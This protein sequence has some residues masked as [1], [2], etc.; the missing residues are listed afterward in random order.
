MII[1][2]LVWKKSSG[3]RI[4]LNRFRTAS[5]KVI[6]S[7]QKVST[8]SLFVYVCNS[9]FKVVPK[10]LNLELIASMTDQEQRTY[11]K[12]GVFLKK[13]FGVIYK[14]LTKTLGKTRALSL[15]TVERW[16][17]GWIDPHIPLRY[18]SLST[19]FIFFLFD[20]FLN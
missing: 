19:F 15:R 10:M 7:L 16:T 3:G 17:E 5:I 2:L 13:S 8:V 6:D 12:F 1:K 9:F 11:V 18:I 20:S 14:E 4:F